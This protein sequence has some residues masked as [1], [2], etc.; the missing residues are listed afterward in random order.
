MANEKIEK[1]VEEPS[2]PKALADADWRAKLS[3]DQYEVTRNSGTERA[4]SGEY[5]DT[6]T[7]GVY[8]CVCCGK[9]LFSSTTKFDSGTGWPS[10][11]EPVDDA[12][13]TDKSDAS[14]GVVRT[15]VVCS[16]CDAHLGHVFPDGPQ[17]TGLRYCI[18]SLAIDLDPDDGM[19]E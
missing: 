7:S 3:R 8:R 14:H 5:C 18:N 16:H 11:Y 15:E 6:K 12:A 1:S 17:P 10:Y 9:S 2:D 13:V 19:K 4:F